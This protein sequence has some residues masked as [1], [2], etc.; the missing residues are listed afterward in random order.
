MEVIIPFNKDEHYS[1]FKLWA[2]QYGACAPPL[3]YLPENG[4]IIPGVCCGFIFQTDSAVCYIELLTCNKNIQEPER[5]IALNLLT[6]SLIDKARSLGF[7]C[8]IGITK[9]E[10]VTARAESQG[11]S[12]FDNYK[13]LIK[14]L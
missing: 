8:L 6:S 9:Y 5:D 1:T 11:Y 4:L 12:V 2:E 7:K 3:D 14:S 10:A 13:L